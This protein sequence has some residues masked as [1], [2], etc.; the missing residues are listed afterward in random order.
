MSEYQTWY[1]VSGIKYEPTIEPVKVSKVTPKTITVVNRW[2]FM[3]ENAPDRFDRCAKE[4]DYDNYF[5]TEREANDFV[6]TKLK[7][8]RDYLAE[9]L[10]EVTAMISEFTERG[11][12][13]Q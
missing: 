12:S 6:L 8:R 3:N 4:S 10:Q 7:T 13:I 9:K 5:P 1:K 11:E 2:T